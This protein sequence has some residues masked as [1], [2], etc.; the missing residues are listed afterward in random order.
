MTVSFIEQIDWEQPWLQEVRPVGE[1]LVSASDWRRGIN[2]AAAALNIN[3]A[4]GL[5]IR[6]VQ[7]ADLPAGVAYEAFISNTGCVPTRENL[8]DFFNAL[9]WLRFPQI[10]RQLN[11]LQA[12]ELS[13]KAALAEASRGSRGRIRDAATIFD[14]N[15]ALLVSCDPGWVTD[16]RMHRWQETLWTRRDAFGKELAIFLFGHALMEKLVKPYKAITAHAW[17]VEAD[18]AFFSLALPQQ[19]AWMDGRV[20]QL[21]E[22]GLT[23]VDFT[24]LSVLGVPGWCAGQDEAFYADANVFRPRRQPALP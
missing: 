7:Q 1:K 11:A 20:A 17:V 19:L 4:R 3:N 9:V 24:P 10:K 8:H 12:A 14:E 18:P 6:F 2:E 16:L 13:R 5:P 15:A 22:Q 23:T 21:L